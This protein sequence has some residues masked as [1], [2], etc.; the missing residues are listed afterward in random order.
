MAV[1]PSSKIKDTTF[2]KLEEPVTEALSQTRTPEN[3]SCLC[4][5]LHPIWTYY[6]D[7]YLYKYRIYDNHID[8]KDLFGEIYLACVAT[9]EN[10][11]KKDYNQI[12]RYFNM[13]INGLLRNKLIRFKDR[14]LINYRGMGNLEILRDPVLLSSLECEDD[15]YDSADSRYD[16]IVIR[17]HIHTQLFSFKEIFDLLYPISTQ[18]SYKKAREQYTGNVYDEY[19]KTGELLTVLNHFKKRVGSIF[20]K[21]K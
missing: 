9:L 15:Q 4:N 6:I 10:L 11:E 2:A 21:I 19:L 8:R 14:G 13:T 18:E 20:G 17:K 16:M 3:I 7:Y 12:K 5:L 1:S